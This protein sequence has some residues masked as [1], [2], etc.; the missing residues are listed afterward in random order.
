M[1]PYELGVL[2]EADENEECAQLRVKKCMKMEMVVIFIK[3]LK[4]QILWIWRDKRK[5]IWDEAQVWRAMK[6]P[7]IVFFQK[8]HYYKN[9]IG[10]KNR[11]TVSEILTEDIKDI[12]EMIKI[13]RNKTIL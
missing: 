13:L 2:L 5:A 8:W 10:W 7:T 1:V 11:R 4:D 9:L 12:Y 6:D 3:S